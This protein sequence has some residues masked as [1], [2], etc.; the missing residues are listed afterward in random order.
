MKEATVP[1]P[2]VKDRTTYNME[3]V[4]V[5]HYRNEERSSY[6][7]NY[8]HPVMKTISS[9]DYVTEDCNVM[10]VPEGYEKKEDGTIALIEEDESIESE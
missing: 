8:S 1:R 9:Y 7:S 3:V 5:H 6:S 2:Q 4:H 10:D